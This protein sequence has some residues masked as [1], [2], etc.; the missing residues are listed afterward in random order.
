MD[1]F[2]L[3]RAGRSV[4]RFGFNFFILVFSVLK[5]YELKTE[6]NLFGSVYINFSS[7]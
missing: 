3:T 4:L 6:P 2:V 7:V 5:L 1:C